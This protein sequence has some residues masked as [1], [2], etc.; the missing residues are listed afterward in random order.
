MDLEKLI[1]SKAFLF[2]DWLWKLLILNFLTLV[3]SIGFVTILPS[4]IAC[5]QTIKDYKDGSNINAF[6][7]YFRNFKNS[8]RRSIV[9][10]ILLVILALVLFY[11]ES[12]YIELLERMGNDPKYETWTTLFIIGKYITFFTIL[13][14][15]MIVVQLPIVYA[16]FYFRTF[17]NLRFAFYVS[18]KFFARSVM[19]LFP[20]LL[21]YL[22]YS[23]RGVWF[24]FGISLTLYL[25]YMVSR[26]TYWQI[27]NLQKEGENEDETGNR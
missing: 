14:V 12:Y 25:I 22:L 26:P 5:F 23:I 19:T 15:I 1:N 6:S 13:I 4:L 20:V 27:I 21:S 2:F 9:L 18:F 16:Y 8:F 3:T 10:G 7:L 11:A 17:D 24:L